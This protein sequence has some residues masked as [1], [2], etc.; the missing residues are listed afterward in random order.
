MIH[1]IAFGH[2]YLYTAAAGFLI[3]GIWIENLQTFLTGLI[4]TAFAVILHVSDNW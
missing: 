4:L 3:T 2:R 1:F